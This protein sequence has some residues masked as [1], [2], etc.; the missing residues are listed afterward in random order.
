MEA[1]R[2]GMDIIGMGMAVIIIM[3]IATTIVDIGIDRMAS[4]FG[5]T[6]KQVS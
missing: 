4:V 6:F 5:S 2:T 1:I 3:V